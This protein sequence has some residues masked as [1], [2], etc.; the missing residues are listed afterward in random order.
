MN[1]AR[2]ALLETSL[3]LFCE[4]GYEGVGIQEI[5]DAAGVTKPTLYHHFGS[6]RGLLDGILRDHFEPF[7]LRLSR[8]VEH[9]DDLPLA[10]NRVTRTFFEFARGAPAFYRLVLILASAPADSES[11]RAFADYAARWHVALVQ[12]FTAASN[13][14]VRGRAGQLAVT[15]LGMINTW[16][17]LALCGDVALDQDLA[18]QAVHQYMHG[19]YA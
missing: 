17:A 18:F 1:S 4:R 14:R 7:L 6:K 16:I 3:R 12:L 15:F 5:V 11:A 10:L 2:T 9:Q 8:A 13:P 19:I